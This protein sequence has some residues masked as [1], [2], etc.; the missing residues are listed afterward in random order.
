MHGRGSFSKLQLIPLRG[1]TG[2]CGEKLSGAGIADN[3]SGYHLENH[4]IKEYNN[5]MVSEEHAFIRIESDIKAGNIPGVVLLAGKEEFLVD[6]YSR[7]LIRK[8]VSETSSSLDLVKPER[9]IV[10]AQTIIESMET[11]SLMSERKVV[12][13]QNFYDDRGRMPEAFNKSE[14]EVRDLREYIEQNLQRDSEGVLLLITYAGQ[15]D[16]REQANIMKSALSK[17]IGKA[18]AVYDFESLNPG[19]LRAF[20]RKRFKDAGKI[21]APGIPGI[22]ARETG[23]GSKGID[24]G[25]YNLENDLKKII[26]HCGAGTEIMSEDV[27][28]VITISPEKNVFEMIDALGQNN[29]DKAFRLLHNLLEDGT[30]E[31]QLLGLITKQLEIMLEAREMKEHGL[32]LAQI[33][34]ALKK[35]DNVH[36]FRTKKALEAGNRFSCRDMERILSS[37]YD[38]EENI[39]TGIM[40]GQLA[41]E[42][43]I[44]QI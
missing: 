4:G 22:I 33:Q 11:V 31:F 1:V 37:A 43:F 40:P 25:L 41:L 27:L 14:S 20:I 38:I 15:K 34:A 10:T 13:L 28:Q 2:I 21:F 35:S 9:D 24:Y 6:D 32:S 17:T 3:V 39:K 44:A 16:E 8:F 12:W 42:Y 26:A 30:G 23:Y 7:K 19:Q 29:K 18:G 36:A 5:L